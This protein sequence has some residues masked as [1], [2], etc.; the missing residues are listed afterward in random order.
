VII[1]DEPT[2]GID[3]QQV[4]EVRESVRALGKDHT[5][6][7]STHILSEAEQMCDRVLI[8]HKGKLVA[9][10]KPADLLRQLQTGTALY[11][12]IGGAS[13]NKG[14]E[15]LSAIP[16]VAGVTWRDGGF[17]VRVSGDA[18]VRG[19]ISARVFNAGWTLLEMRPLATSLES[20]FLELVKDGVS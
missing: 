12:Q 8:I 20:V 6:L 1:L 3:P 5:V 10:G 2:I 19:E 18:D 7:L 4:I 16:H 17:E 15:L 13:K 11:V 14:R 9:Q